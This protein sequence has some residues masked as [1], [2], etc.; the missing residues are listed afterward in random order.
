MNK[1]VAETQARV[2]RSLQRRYWAERRFRAY[3]LLAVLIGVSFVFFLFGT[4][5]S[6]GSSAFRQA[7]LTLPITYDEAVLGLEGARTPEALAGE[8][9][10]GDLERERLRPRRWAHPDLGGVHGR[11]LQ[12][13]P[14]GR[15]RRAVGPEGNA[16]RDC[17]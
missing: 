4:I 5:I 13:Q 14:V 16:R 3:G 12:R 9:A 7:R 1:A 15:F 11:D 8:A 6:Q 2:A 17:A 10:R